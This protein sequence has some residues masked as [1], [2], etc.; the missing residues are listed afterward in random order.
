LDRLERESRLRT[1]C[2]THP[3]VVYVYIIR[4]KGVF[5]RKSIYVFVMYLSL[6][7]T[8]KL[9]LKT[10]LKKGSKGSDEQKENE[11]SYST[12]INIKIAASG[13][14]YISTP[15]LS[16]LRIFFSS[17]KHHAFSTQPFFYH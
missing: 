3:I 8:C 15:H 10:L 12:G 17:Y 2:A 9:H 5:H 4:R 6:Q 13:Y 1:K 7:R 16:S 11:P 14:I